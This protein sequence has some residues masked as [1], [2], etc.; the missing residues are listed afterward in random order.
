MPQYPIVNG[1]AHSWADA[2]FKFNGRRFAGLKSFSVSETMER[3]KTRPTGQRKGALTSGE[4]D[5]EHSI[6]MYMA[7]WQ[8]LL[9]ELGDG[10]MNKRIDS[11]ASFSDGDGGHIHTIECLGCRLKKI[12]D[13]HQQGTEPMT[14]KLDLDVML[15]RR[16]GK[17]AVGAGRP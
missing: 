4:H 11:F 2:G 1:V 12:D 3:G 8:E 7:D 17:D 5:A 15:V 16:D 10:Y 13:S 14:V 9:E 6:E